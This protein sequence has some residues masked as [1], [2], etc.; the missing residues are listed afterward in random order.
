MPRT[1]AFSL[2]VLGALLDAEE[3]ARVDGYALRD[4]G[5][6]V[7]AFGAVSYTHLPLPTTPYV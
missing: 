1:S 4:D 2:D 6:G 5:G 3:R 7:D